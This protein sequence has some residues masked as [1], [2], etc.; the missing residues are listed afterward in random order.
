[1][2]LRTPTWISLVRKIAHAPTKCQW[3]NWVSVRYDAVYTPRVDGRR[4]G[5][6]CSARCAQAAVRV[7][8]Q[9]EYGS[10]S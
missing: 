5:C 9:V 7:P 3:C 4:L 10:A 6:Y 8:M 2:R 1:M